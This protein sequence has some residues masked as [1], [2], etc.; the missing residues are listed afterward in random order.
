MVNTEHK[1]ILEFVNKIFL[2]YSPHYHDVKQLAERDVGQELIDKIKEFLEERKKEKPEEEIFKK[3]V[4]EDPSAVD[5]ED[6]N[7]IVD[8]FIKMR[9]E[10]TLS[11]IE[12][13][14][15]D[16]IMILFNQWVMVGKSPY[17]QLPQQDI[18]TEILTQGIPETLEEQVFEL[19]TPFMK[20]GNYPGA[21]SPEFYS[22]ITENPYSSSK[23]EEF[24]FKDHH[25]ASM[26][27]EEQKPLYK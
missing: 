14:S 7:N 4:F 5:D 13:K 6:I 3:R 27:H 23:T 19:G 1:V 20:E 24:G 21:S 17:E 10:R 26:Y 18:F 25:V 16:D 12:R 11:E 22:T 15:I 8:A 9:S 2:E